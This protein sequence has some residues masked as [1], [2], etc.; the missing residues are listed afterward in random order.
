MSEP[1]VV[2]ALRTKRAEIAGDIAELEHRNSQWVL[3]PGQ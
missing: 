2:A 1:H 3:P